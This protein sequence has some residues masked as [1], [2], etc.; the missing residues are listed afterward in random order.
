[1]CILSFANCFPEL[2]HSFSWVM[3]QMKS[4]FWF[5][6][7]RKTRP[8]LCTYTRDLW[9][10]FVKKGFPRG[11]FSQNFI[12]DTSYKI[13][14]VNFISAALTW[15]QPAYTVAFPHDHK[16]QILLVVIFTESYRGFFPI[17]VVAQCHPSTFKIYIFFILISAYFLIFSSAVLY[18]S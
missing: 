5:K 17:L 3:V 11:I 2:H 14:Y 8:S 6:K 12:C 13:Y 18:T 9:D 7:L 1:M 15:M 10:A 4:S 16:F